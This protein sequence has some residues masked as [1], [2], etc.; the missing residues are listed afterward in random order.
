MW[1]ALGK[2]RQWMRRFIAFAPFDL[3]Y[4]I[5][6]LSACS[7]AVS[8]IPRRVLYLR[9]ALKGKSYWCQLSIK[10]ETTG[11][12]VPMGATATFRA[13]GVECG[14][15]ERSVDGCRWVPHLILDSYPSVGLRIPLTPTRL[16]AVGIA[17]YIFCQVRENIN[18]AWVSQR[19]RAS[20]PIRSSAFLSLG[21]IEQ[22]KEWGRLKTGKY[23][24]SSSTH[25]TQRDDRTLSQRPNMK[26]HRACLS[27]SRY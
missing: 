1:T 27:L 2:P 8:H 21:V 5:T 22:R 19:D 24:I 3:R 6:I 9:I 23:S 4:M 10:G 12:M 7:V 16:S 15:C 20:A 18:N 13:L 17:Q 14:A 26:T 25:P 11:G